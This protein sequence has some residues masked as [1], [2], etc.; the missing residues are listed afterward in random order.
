MQDSGNRGNI[1]RG[2]LDE[3]WNMGLVQKW[4]LG[5]R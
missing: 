3:A 2:I 1:R 5:F 4:K